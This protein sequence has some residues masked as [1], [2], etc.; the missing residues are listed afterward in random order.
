MSFSIGL[1]LLITLNIIEGSL[2][3][4]I[5]NT[6]NQEAPNYFLIDIQP[7]QIDKVKKISN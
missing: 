5:T 3:Y 6:I 2:D 7:N 1:S 4:K